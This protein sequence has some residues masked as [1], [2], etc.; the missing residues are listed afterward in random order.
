MLQP[1]FRT[2]TLFPTIVRKSM[3]FRVQEGS[4]LQIYYNF[5]CIVIV[6]QFWNQPAK[7]SKMQ[8]RFCFTPL[9]SICHARLVTYSTYASTFDADVAKICSS[10]FSLPVRCRAVQ[11]NCSLCLFITNVFTVSP[12][13]CRRFE[14]L[15]DRR[16]SEEG[17]EGKEIEAPRAPK[18]GGAENA[19]AENLARDSKVAAIKRRQLNTFQSLLG[20]QSW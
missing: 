16:S 10:F 17:K 4:Q 18:D 6:S 20:L 2:G 13:R 3:T 7:H 9:S 11:L 8:A 5:Q 15:G 19:G 12:S 1:I 14:R